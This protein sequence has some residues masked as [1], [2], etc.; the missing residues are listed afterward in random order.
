M[1]ID[2][3][4]VRCLVGSRRRAGGP[5]DPAEARVSALGSG[6]WPFCPYFDRRAAYTRQEAQ[7]MVLRPGRSWRTLPICWTGCSWGLP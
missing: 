5:G 2:L 4:L 3:E 7:I 6:C 1:R